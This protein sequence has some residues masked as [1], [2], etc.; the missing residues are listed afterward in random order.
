MLSEN[1]YKGAVN[2]DPV[3]VD[4]ATKVMA[5]LLPLVSK[6]AEEFATQ[7]G[8]AAYD[9]AKSLLS[10]IKQ[11]WSRDKEATETL[12]RKLHHRPEWQTPLHFLT[13]KAVRSP[14]PSLPDL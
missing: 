1:K 6:S 12:V 9:K 5:I 3:I 8:D 2:M 14:L 13:L 7:V 10:T 4:L 11:K